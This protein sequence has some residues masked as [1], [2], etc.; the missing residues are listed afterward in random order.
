MA[1]DKRKQSLYFPEEM[2]KEIQGRSEPTGPLSPRRHP[3]SAL[4]RC[5]GPRLEHLD[6]RQRSGV[7]AAINPCIESRISDTRIYT[8][9]SAGIDDARFA[10]R[11]NLEAALGIEPRTQTTERVARA[12]G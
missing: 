6:A 11:P 1:A 10:R 5:C 2:L 8:P 7:Y 9:I 12:A 3:L 4:A